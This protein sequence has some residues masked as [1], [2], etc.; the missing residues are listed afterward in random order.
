MNTVE[1]DQNGVSKES[2]F[3][4]E[5]QWVGIGI[6]VLEQ[7]SEVRSG[8]GDQKSGVCDKLKKIEIRMTQDVSS[9]LGNRLI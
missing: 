5:H 6:R 2:K 9:C 4:E 8:K 1:E 3:E 7:R